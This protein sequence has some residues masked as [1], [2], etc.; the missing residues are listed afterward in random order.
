MPGITGKLFNKIFYKIVRK[1][2][3]SL[4]MTNMDVNVDLSL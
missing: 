2:L 1:Y 4:E 3:I